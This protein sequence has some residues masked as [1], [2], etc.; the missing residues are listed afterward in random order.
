MADL[1]DRISGE[2]ELG[3]ADDWIMEVNNGAY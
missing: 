1:I 3:R 2:S